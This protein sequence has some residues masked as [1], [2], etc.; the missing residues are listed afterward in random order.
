[1]DEFISF[2]FG[3]VLFEPLLDFLLG[4]PERRRARRQLAAFESMQRGDGSYAGS[5]RAYL[6][7]HV[8]GQRGG[9]RFGKGMLHIDET[10]IVWRSADANQE[11]DLTGAV[12]ISERR[13]GN[14]WRARSWHTLIMRY[15]ND[16][17]EIELQVLRL[18]L[19]VVYAG[20][21]QVARQITS[22]TQQTA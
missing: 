9:A 20:Q 11:R 15:G 6:R 4:I 3:E 18:V 14:G 21:E 2:M 19:P 10:S 8:P 1:M 13:R 17:G 22:P 5:V 12:L 16:A 7:I